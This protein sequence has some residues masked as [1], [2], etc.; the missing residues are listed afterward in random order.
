MHDR[1]RRERT[2]PPPQQPAR[3]P[4]GDGAAPTAT[5]C[6]RLHPQSA[7][8]RA[9]GSRNEPSVSATRSGNPSTRP[10][11]CHSATMSSHSFAE[12][13]G[14]DSAGS[15]CSST[16]AML[17]GA[18]SASAKTIRIAT[19][20]KAATG[21]LSAMRTPR[22]ERRST[23]R[24]RC[25]STTRRRSSAASSGAV[26]RTGKEKGSS[27]RENPIAFP[28]WGSSARPDPAANL[29]ASI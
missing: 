2:R 6:G 24:S 3:P 9:N 29:P 1:C 23:T 16:T 28:R 11:D 15:P 8:T 4:P 5:P 20:R 27:F 12:N 21:R 7:P 18:A 17:V 19:P 10:Q 13:S 14:N 25:R 22:T 26:K